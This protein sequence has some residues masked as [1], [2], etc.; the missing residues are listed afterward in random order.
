V[1]IRF[2]S[3]SRVN[4]KLPRYSNFW[5]GT[6]VYNPYTP[7]NSFDSIATV[8][9][10]SG[11]ASSITFS[12]IPSTYTHLQ[13]RGIAQSSN[14]APEGSLWGR[15][16]GDTN[17]SNYYS[18]RLNGDGSST[19]TNPSQNYTISE[20]GGSGSNFMGTVID[21]LDYTNTNK[22]KTTRALFGVDQNGSGFVG[23]YSMLWM[24]TAVINSITLL[25]NGGNF[26]QYSSFALYGIKG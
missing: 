3:S 11:G 8:N 25:P 10:G 16:N 2:G 19:G 4:N 6:A 22:N 12:S 20:F 1:A 17:T 9:V 7:S 26:T 14:N 15:L 21:I 23:M 18:H 13:I 5:D 24:N